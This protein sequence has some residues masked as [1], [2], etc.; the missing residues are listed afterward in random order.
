[1]GP[2]GLG[3]HRAFLLSWSCAE[4]SSL[5]QQSNLV[6]FCDC[7]WVCESWG[8]PVNWRNKLVSQGCWQPF[9][10]GLFGLGAPGR[11]PCQRRTVL[12][13]CHQ[14][15]QLKEADCLLLYIPRAINTRVAWEGDDVGWKVCVWAE[16]H[17]SSLL[18][19]EMLRIPS[20]AG[21]RTQPTGS[22][23]R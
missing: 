9:L 23:V 21:A 5:S 16:R 6:L 1:M 8:Q 12:A 19:G 13:G 22:Q 17:G 18:L 2:A 20:T 14:C 10:H 3:I 4:D 11:G 7:S 15:D